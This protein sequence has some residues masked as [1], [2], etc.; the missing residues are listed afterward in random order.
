MILNLTLRQREIHL[1]DVKRELRS[2]V[3]PGV[4]KPRIRMW[5]L[6]RVRSLTQ[7]CQDTAREDIPLSRPGLLTLWSHPSRSLQWSRSTFRDPTKSSPAAARFLKLSPEA[8][9]EAWL[10]RAERDVH[11]APLQEKIGQS[12][13]G[14]GVFG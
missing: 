2:G 1:N 12:R 10:S 8:W 3:G 13:C 4:S 11:R 5:N 6:D 9:L 7:H 14:K